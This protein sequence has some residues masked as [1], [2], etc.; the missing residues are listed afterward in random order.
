MTILGTTTM[1]IFALLGKNTAVTI[2]LPMTLYMFGAGIIY[3]NAIGGCTSCFPEKTG[4]ACS[5]AAMFQMGATGL[6]ATIATHLLNID[7]LSL[8]ETLLILST[9]TIPALYLTKTK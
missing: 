4:A 9:S 1:L 6:I 5:L 7:Q 2:V 3:P 8:A